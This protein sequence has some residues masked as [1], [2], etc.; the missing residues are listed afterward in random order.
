MACP[1]DPR[2]SALTRISHQ[3]RKMTPHRFVGAQFIAPDSL[4]RGRDKSRPY[5]FGG[6]SGLKLG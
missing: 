3:I 1:H 2:E 4:G 5:N 6:E